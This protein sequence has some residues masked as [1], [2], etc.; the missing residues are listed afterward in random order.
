MSVPRWEIYF[1]SI[2]EISK[3]IP[4]IVP[5]IPHW[6]WFKAVVY[7]IFLICFYCAQWIS[8][9]TV[10]PILLSPSSCFTNIFHHLANLQNQ[11]MSNSANAAHTS[12]WFL[13]HTRWFFWFHRSCAMTFATTSSV[14]QFGPSALTF[15]YIKHEK[16]NVRSKFLMHLS[17]GN[18]YV[19]QP[20][21]LRFLTQVSIWSRNFFCRIS[22]SIT[23]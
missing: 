23:V 7:Y 5:I 12:Q 2:C 10:P 6:L 8:A 16:Q 15:K 3:P 14:K 9:S 18:I 19:P 17:P 4:V 22:L 13:W 21:H 11:C 20:I 1:L